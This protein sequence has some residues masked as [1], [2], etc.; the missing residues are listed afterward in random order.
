MRTLKL[1]CATL[2]LLAAGSVATASATVVAAAR[3]DMHRAKALRGERLEK[4]GRGVCRQRRVLNHRAAAD[5]GLPGKS[6]LEQ[7]GRVASGGAIRRALG[8]ASQ[9]SFRSSRAG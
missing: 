2:A 9:G 8:C 3:I 4:C 6:R 7:P 5:A 1:T